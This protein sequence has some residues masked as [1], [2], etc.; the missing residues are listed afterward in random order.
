MI[1]ILIYSF[2]RRTVRRNRVR[3]FARSTSGCFRYR[4]L[5]NA[6]RSLSLAAGNT[7]LCLLCGYPVAY[8][9]ARS[10]SHVK[11]ILVALLMCRSPPDFLIQNIRMDFH[12]CVMKDCWIRFSARSEY[13]HRVCYLPAVFIG[14]FYN[15]LPFMVLPLYSSNLHRFDFALVDAARDLGAN[16][17]QSFLSVT[18]VEHAWYFGGILA[19]Y[20]FISR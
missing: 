17:L 19:L 6:F 9:I 20:S 12:F 7:A 2:C 8:F 5:A 4:L 13:K 10:K 1:T 3:V 11:V 15:Y 16:R 14:L 18:S